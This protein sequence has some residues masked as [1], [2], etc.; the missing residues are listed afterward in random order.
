MCKYYTFLESAC[1]D[2]SN[3]THIDIFFLKKNFITK[4]GTLKSPKNLKWPPGGPQTHFK[5]K[6]FSPI[7]L[8]YVTTKLK[9]P[10]KL[11]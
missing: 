8:Y 11:I 3:D 9:G 4:G 7:I 6:I 5:T 1:K 2:G 10:K